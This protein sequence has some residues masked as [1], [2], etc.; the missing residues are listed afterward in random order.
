MGVQDYT[1]CVCGPPLTYA[2]RESPDV[3]GTAECSVEGF[4][5]DKALLTFYHFSAAASPD[6]VE[7]FKDNWQQALSAETY[8]YAFDWGEWEFKP[9]LNYYDL[10]VDDDHHGIWPLTPHSLTGTNPVECEVPPDQ[11]VWVVNCCPRCWDRFVLGKIGVRCRLYEAAIRSQLDLFEDDPIE[12]AVCE[13]GLPAIEV[14]IRRPQRVERPEF[15][16]HQEAQR[17]AWQAKQAQARSQSAQQAPAATVDRH[18]SFE[19]RKPK[20]FQRF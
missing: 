2:C 17:K 3:Q 9:S 18:N 1:C 12:E 8:S 11:S 5:E 7:S 16:E 10:L 13:L 19:E 4:G 15:F 14:E 6:S 20:G